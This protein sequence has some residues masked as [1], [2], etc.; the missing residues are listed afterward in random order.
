[1]RETDEHR[2]IRA[3]TQRF[4]DDVIRPAAESLDQEERFPT[5][6]YAQ[7]AE[8]GLF[9]ITAPEDAGGIG[10]DALAYAIV[11][12]ELSRGYSSVADQ[13][14]LVELIATLLTRHGTP[15]Q[16]AEHLGSVLAAD[17]RVAYCITEAEAGTDV[18]GI[19]TLAKRDGDGWRLSG[20][21]IWIHNAPVAE[22]GFVLARTDPEAGKR[23]MSIFIVDL[24]EEGVSRGVKEHKMGQRASQVGALHFDS[25][26]LPGDALLG[27]EGRGFHIMMSVLDKGRVGIAALAVGIAQAALEAVLGYMPTR[28]QF[29]QPIA[30]FQGLQWMLADMAKDIAAARLLTH[31]AA[32]RLESGDGVTMA[33][34]M[35]KCFAGDA[36]VQHTANAVQIFG[37]SGYI[38]GFEVE[39]L[40]RDAKIT[41]IYE[42]TNQ[43]QR[44]IIA[45]ELLRG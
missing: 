18:S 24:A 16:K 10:M 25:V 3:T 17:K 11:M 40:Y 9:G 44:S 29:G 4:A 35:A 42:G 15:A 39:R 2:Q 1:M 13:C 37:G 19:K 8:L 5:E 21:K 32:A 36:A 41:Q 27:E 38:R 30:D 45:R 26:A 12:E 22:L 28:K 43:I 20:S 6:I 23:G 33:C 31:D 7:M 14:G 34:S